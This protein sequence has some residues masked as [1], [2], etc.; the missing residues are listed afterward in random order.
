M[1]YLRELIITVLVIAL[2]YMAFFNEP[3]Y[4]NDEHI[5]IID[6]LKREAISSRNKA[7]QASDS[8]RE[9]GELAEKYFQ[10]SK[11]KPRM[12]IR[13]I[14]AQDTSRN[15]KL[16]VIQRDSAIRAIFYKK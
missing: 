6:S 9:L 10:M 13:T 11:D 1:K 5:P 3:D 15:R 14:Y 8:A 2:L 7:A 12:I 4:S 16:S